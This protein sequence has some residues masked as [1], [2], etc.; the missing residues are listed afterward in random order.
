MPRPRISLPVPR[1][2]PSTSFPIRRSFASP[3]PSATSP[4]STASTSGSGPSPPGSSSRRSIVDITLIGIAGASLTGYLL[5]KMN[6][7]KSSS[8]KEGGLTSEGSERNAFTIPV[9]EQTG[10]TGTKT[11]A[12]LSPTETNL[13]LTE[14]QASFAVSRRGNPVLRYDTN[15]LASNSPI[16]DDSCCVILERDSKNS[17]IKG[18]LVFWGVFDGHS[19]WQTSRLLSSS[20]VSYVARELDAVFRS[21]SPYTDLLPNNS[22]SQNSTSSSKPSI[23]SLF[24]GGSSS[25]TKRPDLELDTHDP[26]LHQAIKTAFEKL[27]QEI[28]QAPVRLLD[29]IQKEGKL[30]ELKNKSQGHFGIEQSEALNKLLPALSGSCALLAFLDTGRN[31]LHVACT[32]D[33]RAVMGVWVPNNNNNNNNN[34]EEGGSVGGGKWKVCPLSEDQTG[35]N[36]KEVSRIQSEH[37]PDE[38]NTVI[39]RGRVL[40]GLEPTRAFGDARYK[41]PPGQ[42]QALAAAFHPGSVRG[43]PRNYKTPPY[44]TAI[45][46][47]VTVDLSKDD[48]ARTSSRKSIGSFLPVTSGVE[49]PL[50]TRFIVLATD[51]LY[52]RL[53]NQEIVSLVGAHLSGVRGPQTRSSVLSHSV[54]SSPNDLLEDPSNSF[55]HLP[56]QEPTRGEGQVFDFVDGNLA[57]HLTRNALGGAKREQVSVLLS[58]PAPLSR[59]YRDDI[60]C[61]V[62]LLGDP[63]RDGEGGS[64]GVYRRDEG[65]HPISYENPSLK[66][67]L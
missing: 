8:A 24:G 31:K 41:W 54:E 1:L 33:S 28:I 6:E 9:L 22:S 12:L 52:D 60:T 13:R 36:P 47:V 53:D 27:D 38:Q 11:L 50:A 18:D 25:Q 3:P 51:G 40:G 63:A 48:S 30:P 45:P 35:K 58:I 59:R 2:T 42:Q 21:T 29:K 62:I 14:N 34:A 16:E 26:I 64:G 37:P 39:S 10:A 46:E 67:K 43:P 19:G 61:T 44:V 23:W 32:G 4:P 57:T 55:A 17:K 15:H 5:Y 7:R 20:L 66:S 49:Q 65:S 56:R